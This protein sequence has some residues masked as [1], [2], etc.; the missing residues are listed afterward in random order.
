MMNEAHDMISQMRA[1]TISREYGSGGGEVAIRLAQHLGWQLVD[2]EVV[3]RVAQELGVSEAEAEARDERSE[4]LITRMLSNLSM[5]EPALLVGASVSPVSLMADEHTYQEA[6]RQ[7]VT[8][9]ATTG[10]VVIVGR[11]SQVLLADRRDI[12]HVRIVAPL[13]RRIAYVMRREG[14]NQA[15]AQRRIQLKERD[16]DRY[17]QEVHNQHPADPHL[18]DLVVNTGILDLDS[19]AEVIISALVRKATRL[20]TP[21]EDLG[22][23]AGLAPYPGQPGDLRPPEQTTGPLQERNEER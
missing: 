18:Y 23:G 6:L 3:V 21:V 2:H 22:P 19:A 20:A 17:L 16:R 10:H 8:A 5:V 13:E 11:G 9:A 1:V 14:L 4:G 15:A 12:L 7:V